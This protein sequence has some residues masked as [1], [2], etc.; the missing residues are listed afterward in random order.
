MPSGELL[1]VAFHQY[2]LQGKTIYEDM[3]LLRSSDGGRTWSKP[4]TVGLLG[5]EPYLTILEDGTVF[6]TVHLLAADVRN[7]DGYTYSLVHRSSDGGRT[8]STTRVGPEGFASPA[9]TQIT[10]NVLALPG[11]TLV[12]GASDNKRNDYLWRSSDGGRTWDKSRR[13]KALDFESQYHFFGEAVL[14]RHKSGKLLNLVRVDSKEFPVPNKPLGQ[15]MKGWNDNQ[16]HLLLYESEDQGMTFRRVAHFTEYGEIYPAV[17]RLQDGRLL[18]TFTVRSMNPPLGVHAVLG[19]E[20][21]ES[22]AFDFN[23]DRFVLD[24]K[25]PP[26]KPSGGGFGR[27][28]QLSDGTLV[29]SFSWRGEDNETRLEVVRWRLPR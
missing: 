28:V 11:G 4:Q 6:I 10:R 29:T 1:M 14:F 7:K 3:L 25:T 18:M 26:D 17:I 13:T 23:H 24:A 15:W 16:D 8:W 27:T 22:F 19:Q 2:P 9:E 21:A 5:R 12:L 20:T